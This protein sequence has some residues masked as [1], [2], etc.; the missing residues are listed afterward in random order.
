MDFN[1]NY[2]NT[3]SFLSYRVDDETVHICPD[4]QYDEEIYLSYNIDVKNAINNGNISS[5]LDLL[6]L[7]ILL[8]IL[9]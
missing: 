6:F 5:G 1:P 2:T 7:V 8:F 9:F 4:G 3:K